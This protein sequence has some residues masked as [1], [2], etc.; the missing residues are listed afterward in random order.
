MF[1][2]GID[3]GESLSIIVFDCI[4]RLVHYNDIIIII[5]IFWVWMILRVGGGF[6]FKR[7]RVCILTEEVVFVKFAFILQGLVFFLQLYIIILCWLCRFKM[8]QNNVESRLKKYIYEGRWYQVK[9]TSSKL[10]EGFSDIWDNLQASFYNW[11]LA[12]Y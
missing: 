10:V 12:I 5:V 7:R 8:V 1:R 6:I 2:L 3:S 11:F 9:D 4:I